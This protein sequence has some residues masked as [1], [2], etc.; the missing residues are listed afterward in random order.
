[1]DAS[2]FDRWTQTLTNAASRRGLLRGLAGATLGAVAARVSDV[3]GAKKNKSKKLSR[4]SFGC[5][6]VG[7]ACRGNSANCCSGICEGNKPKKDKKDKSRCVAHHTSSCQAT[8]DFCEGILTD[9][10][11]NG[12]CAR[13]T[14][15]A[16]FCANVDGLG[17]CTS[18]GED[19]DCEAAYGPGAACVACEA[20]C[21]D[22]QHTACVQPD[23]GTAI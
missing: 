11:T 21:P 14:G 23:L 16:S 1:M 7:K 4:N 17:A 10:G 20:K 3:A 13:T 8:G 19:R 9:C 18:C 12:V 2:Q 6:D 22:G 5:V 15:R